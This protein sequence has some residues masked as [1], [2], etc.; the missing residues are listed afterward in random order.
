MPRF[1]FH[2]VHGDRKILDTRGRECDDLAAAKKSAVASARN[3]IV[4]QL[5]QDNP[6]PNGRHFE[7]TDGKDRPLAKVYFGDLLPPEMRG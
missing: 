3:C 4:E 7:I 5:L 6:H 2:L 1:H